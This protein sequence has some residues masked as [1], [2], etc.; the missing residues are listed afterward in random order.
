MQEVVRPRAGEAVDRELA[1]ASLGRL[2]SAV[3]YRLREKVTEEHA[4]GVVADVAVQLRAELPV[5][6]GHVPVRGAVERR[7]RGL[8]RGTALAVARRRPGRVEGDRP[9]LLP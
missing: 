2:S 7:V 5:V 4:D 6:E 9:E 3:L 8:L 1:L